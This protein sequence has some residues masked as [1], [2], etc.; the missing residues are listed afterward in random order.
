LK[1]R[2]IQAPERIRSSTAPLGGPKDKKHKHTSGEKSKMSGIQPSERKGSGSESVDGIGGVIEVGLDFEFGLVGS[3]SSA[4]PPMKAERMASVAKRVRP[5]KVK[6]MVMKFNAVV[7]QEESAKKVGEETARKT[8]GESVRKVSGMGLED[9][10]AKMEVMG[11]LDQAE[12]VKIDEGELEDTLGDIVSTYHHDDMS[13]KEGELRKQSE[14]IADIYDYYD[15]YK[16]V[17][18]AGDCE[19]KTEKV[20]KTEIEIAQKL[21]QEDVAV[22]INEM[23]GQE[24]KIEKLDETVAPIGMA[25]KAWWVNETFGQDS[26]TTKVE[27]AAHQ[28]EII[29]AITQSLYPENNI[30]KTDDTAAQ[31]LEDIGIDENYDRDDSSID[32]DEDLLARNLTGLTVGVHSNRMSTLVRE[33]TMLLP[34]VSD[35][36]NDL[37]L[38]PEP[39]IS[40]P[41][42][43]NSD[44]ISPVT[45]FDTV[46]NSSSSRPVTPV[47]PGNDYYLGHLSPSNTPLLQ[48]SGTDE[49]LLSSH[50]SI[51]SAAS[52]VSGFSD[53]Y[54]DYSPSH[55][56]AHDTT[57][58]T[59]LTT[60]S[61]SDPF[62]IPPSSTNTP[63]FTTSSTPFTPQ[64]F[65]GSFDSFVDTS[66]FAPFTP[67]V[68]FEDF[69]TF[70]PG[71]F[72]MPR[73]L[74]MEGA[75]MMQ[76]QQD[77]E[78][79]QSL[80]DVP[81]DGTVWNWDGSRWVGQREDGSLVLRLEFL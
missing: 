44:L 46:S 23:E 54:S 21:R 28:D 5:G 32:L 55:C 19:E 45:E 80:L 67:P 12:V 37:E 56:L 31:L 53:N 60:N 41:L 10:G 68:S 25:A 48:R 70:L 35:L 43:Q 74:E 8:S 1:I 42:H 52:T 79:M 6:E 81:A 78:G 11:A 15:T 76:V 16:G 39:S 61:T 65:S 62:F 75:G 59:S 69:I 2:N 63:S 38:S 73:D 20:E 22:E 7:E 72:D 33:Y 27:E 77:V 30:L 51:A 66:A 9:Q 29:A 58:S 64:T 13:W 47:D 3:C 71:R 36:D 17:E 24:H 14:E 49:S 4:S 57:Q 50:H 26:V 34:Q 40:P 18:E